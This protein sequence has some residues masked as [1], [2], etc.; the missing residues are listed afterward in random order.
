MAWKK[1]IEL[2]L[3][4]QKIRHTSVI[5][6]HK[7][8]FIW[9]QGKVHAMQ[10][11]CPH[12]KLPLVKGKITEECAIVCP[13][14]KSEFDMNTGKANCWSTWPPGIG[15]LLGKVSRPKDLKIYSTRVDEGTI[16]VEIN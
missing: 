15:P 5:D 9:H 11:Q 8:L 1:A 16:N 14:H 7:I 12:L 13:F 6:G 4:Q 2:S 3:L 10:S